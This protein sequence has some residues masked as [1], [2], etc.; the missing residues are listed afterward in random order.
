[1]YKALLGYLEPVARLD[2]LGAQS[3]KCPAIVSLLVLAAP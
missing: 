3:K 2:L 1:M